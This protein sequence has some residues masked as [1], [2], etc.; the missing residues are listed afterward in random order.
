MKTKRNMEQLEKDIINVLA[1]M[2]ELLS[3]HSV[4]Y[5]TSASGTWFSETEFGRKWTTPQAEI[6]YSSYV[7]ILAELEEEKRKIGAAGR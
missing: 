2:G 4:S 1:R 3:E 7:R 6:T 5:L